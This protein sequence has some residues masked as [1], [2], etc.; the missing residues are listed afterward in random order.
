MRRYA[1]EVRGVRVPVIEAAVVIVGSGAASL[2]GAVHCRRLGIDDVL[3]VTD[4]LGGGVS[5]NA[6]SDKQTYYRLNPGGAPDGAMEMARDLFSGGCMHGDIALVE[7]ALS[8]REFFHLVELGVDFPRNRY[9]EFAGFRT[10]HD[11]RGRG[12]SAGPGTSMM[13]YEKLLDEVRLLDVPVADGLRVIDIVIIAGADGGKVIAGLL[14]LND[15]ALHDDNYGLTIIQAEYCMYGTGGP[16]GLYC[17]SVY[18]PSQRGGLGAALAAG[19]AAQNLTES[20]FGIAA[21]KIRWNLSGSYQQVLPRYI[22]TEQDGS[23]PKEFLNG[24]FTGPREQLTAQF[25]KGYQ[26]PFDVRKAGVDGSSLIDLAVHYECAVKGRRVFM[27]YTANPSSDSYAFSLEDLQ[28]VVRDYLEKSGATGRLP[29]ER[30]K[31]MNPPAFDLLLERGI[32]PRHEPIEIA[33][34]HQHMNGG[35]LGSIWWESGIGNLFPV[36]ECNGSHGIYRP[37]GSALNSG[38]VGSLRAAECIAH[39]TKGPGGGQA[40]ITPEALIRAASARMEHFEKLL[41]NP[42]KHDLPAQ[43]NAIRERVSASLG[44]ER[45]IGR[46]RAALKENAA[47]LTALP[48]K[49]IASCEEI[50]GYLLNEDLLITEK[51]FLLSGIE[52]LRL[53]CG[54]RGSYIAGDIGMFMRELRES[55]SSGKPRPEVQTD[56]S[57]NG[58]ILEITFDETMEPDLR[59]VDVRE[60]PEDENWFERVWADYREGRIYE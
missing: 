54:G 60:I 11:E 22:S 45:N 10:D 46:L 39:R 3:V 8:A 30:L 35:L 53:L 47:M 29:W 34:C 56:F 50:P 58:K 26:W 21:V 32:D 7:A 1:T 42:V 19:A 55:I 17:D 48:E 33:V 43:R 6:G 16:G 24:Y 18:P 9:G 49:G 38:Q 41:A 36:G 15:G 37:G 40:G 57:M 31:Q 23:D 59:W 4:M 25:L 51:A 27:D 13:M 44:I 2:N 14:A 52:T 12:T 5:A 20:Q 28:D